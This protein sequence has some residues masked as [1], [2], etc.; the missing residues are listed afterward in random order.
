MANEPNE[1][2]DNSRLKER[3]NRMSGEGRSKRSPLTIFVFVLL[4]L[5]AVPTLVFPDQTRQLFGLGTSKSEDLQQASKID[6][7][8]LSTE[9]FRESEIQIEPRPKLEP[10][11]IPKAAQSNELDAE[12]AARIAALEKALQDMANRPVDTGP[13]AED[14]KKLLDKQAKNLREE[15]DA[16]EQVL[17][18]QLDALRAQSSIPKGLSADELSEQEKLRLAA[19][20]RERLRKELTERKAKREAELLERMVS[21]GN[22]YDESEGKSG[23]GAKDGETGIRELSQNEQFL[24]TTAAKGFETS[25]ASQLND[26]S[27]IIVQGTIISAVLETAINTELPGNIRAQVTQ[28]VY[29]FDGQ[30]VLMPAGTRLIGTYNSEISIAQKRVLVAWN[31]AITP[32]GKSVKL[33]ATGT[34]R[35]G[36]AGQN[37]NVNTRF[38]QRFGTAALISSIGAIPAFLANDDTTSNSSTSAASDVAQNVADDLKDTTE[39]VLEEYL[40]LPPIISVPQGTLMTV[41]VN[42]DLD[43]T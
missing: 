38:F 5:I 9:I 16:R 1:N 33:T 19:Q 24:S 37:G 21:D 28:S 14:I 17:R 35:L 36:R 26:I 6:S 39:D 32:E 12:A 2:E 23:S 25:K 7:S 4:L 27:N 15:A 13:S 43:F 3:K 42:Q 31:R 11:V 8:G 18:A 20:E 29:S 30:T 34:D 40:S 41:L 22:V 10:I